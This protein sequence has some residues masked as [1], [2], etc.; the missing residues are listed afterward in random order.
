MADQ[1]RFLIVD[2]AR[3][4]RKMVR[5]YLL[6]IR[7][8]FD[9]LEAADGDEALRLI[10][11]RGAPAFATIDF[12]MPGMNGI[13][14]AEVIQQRT[15]DAKLA[16]LTANVQTSMRQRAAELGLTFLA[17]PVSREKIAAFLDGSA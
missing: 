12:N 1:D 8:D 17:K 15:P 4:A 14:L 16:L 2:D 7:T 9:V 5:M 10:E 6:A 11:E 3:L 13:E